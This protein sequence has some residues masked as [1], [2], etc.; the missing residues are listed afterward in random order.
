MKK[1]LFILCGFA[2]FMWGLV[3][4]QTK[5]WTTHVGAEGLGRITLCKMRE[6]GALPVGR[7]FDVQSDY[8]FVSR[9]EE[10]LVDPS[11][12]K[13]VIDI[14]GFDESEKSI[15]D[16]LSTRDAQCRARGQADFCAIRASLEATVQIVKAGDDQYMVKL[17]RIHRADWFPK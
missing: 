5:E 7:L 8:S 11:C 6:S 15:Q 12:E 17:L 10:Y 14:S 13:G 4:C 9:H 16:F 3:G 1:I 2:T